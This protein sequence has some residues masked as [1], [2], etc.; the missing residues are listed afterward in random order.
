MDQN[1]PDKEHASGAEDFIDAEIE[2][3]H[4]ESPAAEMEIRNALE[5]LSG[6]VRL[7]LT[8]GSVS[9]RYDPTLTSEKHIAEAIVAAGH[10]VKAV[11]LSRDA[12]HPGSTAA[13]PPSEEQ[14]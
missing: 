1:Q 3:A 6:I 9:V 14:P 12:G 5:K 10:E 11:N 13:P 2:A 7:D 8:K 4:M